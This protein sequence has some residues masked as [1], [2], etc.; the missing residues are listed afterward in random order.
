M[1]YDSSVR[2]EESGLSRTDNEA[3]VGSCP[4]YVQSQRWG[5]LEITPAIAPFEWKLCRR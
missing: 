4:K 2:Y 1:S 5:V 3:Q